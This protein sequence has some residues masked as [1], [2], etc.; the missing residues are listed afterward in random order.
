MSYVLPT[1]THDTA[2][3]S[4]TSTLQ[5][6]QCS[7]DSNNDKATK[8]KSDLNPEAQTFVPRAQRVQE[9]TNTPP[10]IG[11]R[12]ATEYPTFTPRRFGQRANSPCPEA[13]QQA[14][15]EKIGSGFDTLKGEDFINAEATFRAILNENQGKL[16]PSDEQNTLI[17]LAR[18]LKAQSQEKQ[19]EAC[20]LLEKLRL[21]GKLTTLKASTI[22]NLDL[23]LSQCER[24]LGRYPDAEARLLRL[25]KINP[26][27]D[28]TSFCQPSDNFDADMANI[29]LWQ[30]MEKH[31]LTE[32]LLYNM[33]AVLTINLQSARS[34]YAIQKLHKNLH[35]V[36]MAL[37]IFWQ[38]RGKNE[39]AEGLL[40]SMIGVPP[41]GSEEFLY[42]PFHHDIKLVL[43]RL[44]YV[45]DKNNQAERL[46]LSLSNKPPY[47]SEEIMCTPSNHLKIDLALVRLW[48]KMGRYDKA[49]RLLL[50]MSDKHLGMSWD[51]LCRPCGQHVIDLAQVRLWQVMD[52]HELSERLLLNMS[53][54]HPDD[55]EG[56]LCKPFGNPVIDITLAR[57]WELAGK[58]NLTERLL[59]NMCG[60]DPNA[61][62][63][64]LCTPGENQEIDLTRMRLWQL[65]GK[66]E[67]AERLTL[68]MRGKPPNADED[69]LCSPSGNHNIDLCQARIWQNMNKYK[70]SE[71]LLLNMSHK[72]PNADED[73]LSKPSGN[74]EVDLALFRL[75][76]ITGRNKLAESLLLIMR[77]THLYASEEE[78]CSPCGNKELD[79]N[80][81]R[82]WEETD[83][84]HLSERLLLNMS[85]KH[86]CDSEDRL[87]M[88]CGNRTIDLAM[89]RLWQKTGRYEW[90]K[91]LIMR[92]CDL[93]HSSECE[94]ALF[95]LF[96]G[97][98]GFLEMTSRFP[99]SAN[100]LLASSIHYFR[101]ACE[102]I[103]EDA[104][105]SGKDNL[106][107][108][109]ELV[110][111]AL[112]KYPP[113]AGAFSQ[114]AHCLRMMGAGE[115]EWR[116]WFQKANFLDPNRLQKS[117]TDFWRSKESAALQKLWDLKE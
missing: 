108:A 57:H 10:D 2:S 14:I 1:T 86:P 32:T 99:L 50:N 44:W 94:L 61:S 65:M 31:T 6:S 17:G 90:A 53:H 19:K 38:A 64:T 104:P 41:N 24:A 72:H 20:H 28:E 84:L 58:Y 66:Y 109:L 40:L 81:A 82:H 37:A 8:P 115:K 39:W 71:R 62:E 88:P 35:I 102:Q 77:G 95:S 85:S 45:M 5:S 112:E 52:K 26:D 7:S 42:S 111:S 89:V 22:K 3:S 78:R 43:A 55:S 51:I 101:L 73:T 36:T 100:T 15:K 117:K 30:D 25:R 68:N 92:C 116:E 29:Q 91:V 74:H 18:S 98:T 79:L 93:Y 56:T 83:N 110:E 63:D 11:H 107:K 4:T 48:Q 97:Q 114:K 70:L 105:R 76:K 27:A 80:L 21:T 59:L 23:T 33:R 106:K 113:S 49:E 69:T 87:C 34:T 47:A 54:K 46:L 12:Q 96:A 9:C 75:W 16:I 103:T 67:R 60:V 13:T